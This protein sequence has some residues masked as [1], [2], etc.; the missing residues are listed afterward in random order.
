METREDID[1]MRVVDLRDFLKRHSVN[2]AEIPRQDGKPGLPRKEDLKAAAYNVVDTYAAGSPVR[3]R[4]DQNVFQSGIPSPMSS[5]EN[6]RRNTRVEQTTSPP[7]S[8]PAQP[9]RSPQR[10]RADDVPSPNTA[11]AKRAKAKRR[12]S[13]GWID[14]SLL[15]MLSESKPAPSP[16]KPS[17]RTSSSA[18]PAPDVA[19][20]PELEEPI[21]DTVQNT[22]LPDSPGAAESQSPNVIDV[23]ASNPDEDILIYSESEAASDVAS[24]AGST[25]EFD[26]EHSH[27]SFVD[28]RITQLQEWLREHGVSYPPRS[29]KVELV[30]I[31]RAHA[32]YMETASTDI[33]DVNT[34]TVPEPRL[35]Y[36]TSERK[37]KST[38]SLARRRR[39]ITSPLD[40]DDD[41][42]DKPQVHK[43]HSRKTKTRRRSIGERITGSISRING[44]IVLL[45]MSLVLVAALV[46]SIGNAYRAATRPY[47]DTDVTEPIEVDGIACRLCPKNGRCISGNVTCDQSYTLFDNACVEDQD[48]SRYADDIA[49]RVYTALSKLAGDA[50]CGSGGPST[51]TES[52]LKKAFAP[53]LSF[54]GRDDAQVSYRTRRQRFDPEK[55]EAAFD[56]ALQQLQNDPVR[57]NIH[58][59]GD[60]S[61]GDI[62]Y[63]SNE[64]IFSFKC[65]L[66]RLLWRNWKI[67][68]AFVTVVTLYFY[69]SY[70]RNRKRKHQEY[71]MQVY[72]EACGSLLHQKEQ[73]GRGEE[74]NGFVIDIQ[75]R[76]ELLG[77]A[78]PETSKIWAEVEDHLQHD[79]RVHRSGPRILD[80]TPCYVWEWKGRLS[81]GGSRRSSLGSRASYASSFSSQE[82]LAALNTMGS[83]Q[84]ASFMG[85]LR[86]RLNAMQ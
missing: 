25:L 37:G 73:Y 71:I 52:E 2:F 60:K 1:E 61:V 64:P 31:A 72:N 35:N 33:N 77:R 79:T 18:I 47:C 19:L 38:S 6:A 50:Q 4:P 85:A 8:P 3:A 78:T 27:P 53:N 48:V 34:V 39:T 82:N 70:Q 74:E 43:R 21:N 83:P 16:A 58:F 66:S 56:K 26:D 32:L 42:E 57:F 9:A 12:S 80:G 62:V 13:V 75:L 44:R 22:L 17:A 46:V 86:Q 36:R 20:P 84:Q 69:I 30:S 49:K 45:L 40:D 54:E 24:D 11:S 14:P 67:V 41:D 29:R 51:L 81:L 28:M 10:P 65:Q 63:Q 55:Y 23:D 7:A 76:D 15:A 68:T 59:E 5:P